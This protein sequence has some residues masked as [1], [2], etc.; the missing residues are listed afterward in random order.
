MAVEN[1]EASALPRLEEGSL[2]AAPCA[3]E[4]TMPYATP[5]AFPSTTATNGVER[6]QTPSSTL[7]PACAS[8]LII[9]PKQK[10]ETTDMAQDSDLGGELPGLE[11]KADLTWV[12]AEASSDPSQ[13]VVLGARPKGSS[14]SVDSRNMDFASPPR[15]EAMEPY[16]AFAGRLTLD[17]T[18]WTYYAQQDEV[19]SNVLHLEWPE[20]LQLIVPVLFPG[21]S[22][23]SLH[24]EWSKPHSPTFKGRVLRRKN[25][26]KTAMAWGNTQKH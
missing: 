5:V 4:D 26:L 18:D 24:R 16:C 19:R 21:G 8:W 23:R 12:R 9:S 15:E 10:V 13:P 3:A 25:G 6:N 20:S 1:A 22:E 11:K 17:R 2:A 14:A 7:S